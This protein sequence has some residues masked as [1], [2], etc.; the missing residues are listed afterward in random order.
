[1]ATPASTLETSFDVDRVRADFPALH[2]EVH[3]Q[4]LVYLDN[5]ATAQK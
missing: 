1:M 4:P 2:Q 3:G 5:A